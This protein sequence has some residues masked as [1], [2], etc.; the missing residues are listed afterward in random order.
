MSVFAYPLRYPCWKLAVGLGIPVRADVVV[1]FDRCEQLF[2]AVC[3]DFDH[4][5]PIRAQADDVATLQNELD[6]L[7]CSEMKRHFPKDPLMPPQLKVSLKPK[8]RPNRSRPCCLAAVRHVPLC[9][10]KRQ[11]KSLRPDAIAVKIRDPSRRSAL[12]TSPKAT[13][14]RKRPLELLAAQPKLSTRDTAHGWS[15]DAKRFCADW[16]ARCKALREKS[17]LGP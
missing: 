13:F 4:N 17:P 9:A 1:S 6:A 5:N 12:R 11:A 3:Y 7:F 14:C 10:W 15:R 2:E 16:L 8:P